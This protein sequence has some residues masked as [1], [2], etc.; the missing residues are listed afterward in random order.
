M[1]WSVIGFS[2]IGETAPGLGGV[3]VVLVGAGLYAASFADALAADPALRNWKNASLV[4]G[5]QGMAM[6]QGTIQGEVR[7]PELLD[8]RFQSKPRGFTIGSSSAI[9]G[10]LLRVK[11]A[12]IVI[13]DIYDR[14]LYVI[15]N[16][17]LASS[18][19]FMP[20]DGRH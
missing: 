18:R 15:H 9:H 12:N 11:G 2:G 6:V 5:P 1:I 8:I 17:I 10:I 14:P 16:R 20:R 4:I 3:V 13:A 19:R 7:W